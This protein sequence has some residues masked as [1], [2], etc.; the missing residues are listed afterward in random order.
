MGTLELLAL[1]VAGLVQGFLGF[2]YGILATGGLSLFQELQYSASIVNV[3]GLVTTGGLALALHR[4]SDW[5]MVRRLSPG[6][7]LGI[8]GGMYLLGNLDTRPLKLLLGVS[9]IAIAAWNLSTWRPRGVAPGWYDAPVS[10]VSGLFTG[11]F[12]MGG[13]PLLAHV[14]RRDATPD[15][16]R[17]T[18]QMVLLISVSFRLVNAFASGM[19]TDA[20]WR[21]SAI[22]VI[23]SIFGAM[24]GLFLGRF[25]SRQRFQRATWLALVLFGVGIAFSSV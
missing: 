3:T 14:Y 20:V 1:F 19:L 16:L 23:A 5:R 22:G 7:A 6:I 24:C 8:I 15:A 25:V 13:P 18:I 10:L 2:G 11:L 17:A 4:H 9:I 21:A 12:N